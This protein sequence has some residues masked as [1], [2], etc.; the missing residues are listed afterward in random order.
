MSIQHWL[1]QFQQTELPGLDAQLMLAPRQRRELMEMALA[2][3]VNARQSAV[4]VLLHPLAGK[5]HFA[6][7]RRN[8]YAGVHSDQIAFPGGRWEESDGSLYFTAQRETLEELGVDPSAYQF[9][10]ALTP[11]YIPPS[12]F[13]MHPFV[14]LATQPVQ[15]TP[16]PREVVQVFSVSLE[17]FLAPDAVR[18]IPKDTSYQ[19]FGTVPAFVWDELEVWGATA[20]VLSEFREILLRTPL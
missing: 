4:M 9:V 3:G 16:D 10:K 18:E 8:T 6:L 17:Q 20:M 15:F 12:N 19:A 5:W 7:I 2:T 14:T 11:L 1:E 13:M